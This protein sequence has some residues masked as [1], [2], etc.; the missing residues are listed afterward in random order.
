MRFIFFFRSEVFVDVSWYSI[1]LLT[2][3]T[4]EPGMYLIAATLPS[5]RP[6]LGLI[7]QNVDFSTLGSRLLHYRTKG[8]PNKTK[9]RDIV[10]SGRSDSAAPTQGG[11]NGFRQLVDKKDETGFS[12]LD[13]SKR[14]VACYRE[15][16]RGSHRTLDL[17]SEI[18]GNGILFQKDFRLSSNLR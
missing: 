18:S 14:L 13:H 7:F 11:R 5:L 10:L 9:T 4:I 6:L 1:E 17:E 15:D 16:D 12:S 8:S 3:T 2:W